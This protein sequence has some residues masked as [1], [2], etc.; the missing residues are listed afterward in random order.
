MLSS[1]A[2]R[3]AL[4]LVCTLACSSTTETRYAP[5]AIRVE[6]ARTAYQAGDVVSISLQNIGEVSVSYNLCPTFLEQQVGPEWISRGTPVDLF[7]QTGCEPN[8]SGLAPGGVTLLE[9][10]LAPTLLPGTYRVRFERFRTL[11]GPELLRPEYHVSNTFLI[12]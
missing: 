10:R 7:S 1:P 4:I 8:A 6:T 11:L 5:G 9:R 12:Q 2:S 3:A